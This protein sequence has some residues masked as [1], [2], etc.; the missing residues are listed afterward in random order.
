MIGSTALLVWY[1]SEGSTTDIQ[2][3]HVVGWKVEQPQD[4]QGT[5]TGPSTTT[6]AGYADIMVAAT[7]VEQG[8]TNEE[9]VWICP[10]ITQEVPTLD[11]LL[12]IWGDDI[13][14]SAVTHNSTNPTLAE[15]T[16]ADAGAEEPTPGTGD[17]HTDASAPA[18]G[19]GSAEA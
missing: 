10:D 6:L 17:V 11:N 14:A 19:A 1:R 4:E 18:G 15:T 8:R 9:L 5:P 13:V 7:V 3:G 16:E 12:A 2:C